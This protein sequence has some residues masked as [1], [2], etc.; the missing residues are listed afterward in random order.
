MEKKRGAITIM[1]VFFVIENAKWNG[2]RNNAVERVYSLLNHKK[3]MIS[4]GF[5]NFLSYKILDKLLLILR[6]FFFKIRIIRL[7]A[8][9]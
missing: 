2:K 5:C 1:S 9:L 7:Q 6:T 4:V 3:K 8:L